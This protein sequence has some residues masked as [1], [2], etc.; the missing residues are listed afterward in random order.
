M[1]ENLAHLLQGHAWKP[2]HE[3]RHIRAIFKILEK[4]RYWHS[5]SAKDPCATNTLGIAIY[6]GTRRPID[7]DFTLSV[8]RGAQRSA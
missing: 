5:R 3:F 2:A 1:I 4:S 7:H 6:G 8:A